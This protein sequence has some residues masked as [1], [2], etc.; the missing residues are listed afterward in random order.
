[1]I[2][3]H[4]GSY[5]LVKAMERMSFTYCIV[6]F[7]L[8]SSEYIIRIGMLVLKHTIIALQQNMHSRCPSG[9][10]RR[11]W[12]QGLRLVGGWR[13]PGAPM[14]VV[15][16]GWSWTAGADGGLEARA[17]AQLDRL[18][19]V[20]VEGKRFGRRFQSM[21]RRRR[22]PEIGPVAAGREGRSF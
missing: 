21:R 7:N 12:R 20:V 9:A 4:T 3:A 19:V 6:E 13:M 14:R 18:R 1:F 11:P 17:G 5:S 16:V 15:Q 22:R 2:H 8:D 10:L